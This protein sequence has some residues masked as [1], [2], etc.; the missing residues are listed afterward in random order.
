MEASPLQRWIFVK[1]LISTLAA[2]PARSFSSADVGKIGSADEEWT[3]TTGE[4]L[5]VESGAKA[6]R[7]KSSVVLLQLTLELVEQAVYFAF[8]VRSV[9]P[10]NITPGTSV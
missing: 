8:K 6:T 2:R 10:T 4:C 3:S 1:F 7:K 9:L 5:I